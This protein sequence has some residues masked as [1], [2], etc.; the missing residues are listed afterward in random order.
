MGSEISIGVG[1]LGSEVRVW[2]Q[3]SALGSEVSIGV[4]GWHRGRDFGV[5][6][7]DPDDGLGVGVR[8]QT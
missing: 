1:T 4:K 6:G 2:G 7:G 3:G 8:D 5:R